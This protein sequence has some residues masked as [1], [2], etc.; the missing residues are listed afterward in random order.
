M[1]NIHTE[2]VHLAQADRHVAIARNNVAS[3][4]ASVLCEPQ[5]DD[6]HNRLETLRQTLA[7]FEAHRALI[8]KTIEGLR[9]GSLPDRTN[10]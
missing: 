2:L 8:A 9:D 1:P 7:V 4:E 5:P 10:G 6:A 3:A